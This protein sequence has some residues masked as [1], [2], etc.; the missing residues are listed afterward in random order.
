MKRSVEVA[1]V[2]GG[3]IGCS[4]AYN[5]ARLGLTDVAVYERHYLAAGSTGRCGAGV[6]AQWGTEMN[7]LLA[8]GSIRR[9]ER[10]AEELDYPS[11]EFKQ[12][13]YLILAFSE[14]QMDQ[15]RKNV[16]LQNRLE[17][18]SR[19]VTPGEARRIVPHLGAPDLVGA[20]FSNTDGHCNP[21]KVTDAYA[22]AARRLGVEI[23][24][25]TG[26][27]GFAVEH[28][29]ITRVLTNRGPVACRH[30]VNASG[31]YS[32]V[33]AAMAGVSLPVYSQ[34]HQVMVTEPVAP[35]QDPMVISFTHGLYCQQTPHGSF[36]IG[37]GDPDEPKGFDTGH[38]WQFI[39]DAARKI[40]HLLPPLGRLRV[41]RQWSGLYNMTPD[42]QP[43]LGPAPE[44]SN[45]WLAV[46]YSGHGFMLAPMVGLIIA[47]ELLGQEPEIPAVKHLDLG[48]FA[49]GELILEPSV[50]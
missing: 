29:R 7:C 40:A 28:G 22:R 15:F 17:I 47:Q 50:V 46:G 44:P 13:G 36:I 20:T 32:Q 41:V 8:S 4:I 24:T 1:I 27:T 18:P 26:V 3:V 48:R 10:L 2:G 11:I 45:F 37:L 33:T 39:A 23:N 34:R 49:R 43:I 6:R 42:A 35:M 31:P 19:L 12:G 30:V 5:L 14:V 16:S 9:F 38:T 25:H 21:F